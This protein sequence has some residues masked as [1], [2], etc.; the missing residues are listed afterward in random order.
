MPFDHKDNSP[1]LHKDLNE[2]IDERVQQLVDEKVRAEL[3]RFSAMGEI[4]AY[5]KNENWGRHANARSILPSKILPNTVEGVRPIAWQ[6]L[7][8]DETNDI[9]GFPTVP[10]TKIFNSSSQTKGSGS[11]K[12]VTFDT[13]PIDTAGWADLSSN[14]INIGQ[15]GRVR[16]HGNVR[17]DSSASGNRR[18]AVIYL[19]GSAK[20]SMFV[21]NPSGGN[22]DVSVIGDLEVAVDDYVELYSFQDTGSNLALQGGD[23]IT[24]LV[25]EF[26]PDAKDS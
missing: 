18:G 7:R 13:A 3:K 21:A 8:Y 14:R 20:G 16:V 23:H 10:Y 2:L 1:V 24:F 15:A 22:A 4:D 9:V 19:N 26:L 11:L 12:K 25:V 6:A 17:H 5:M